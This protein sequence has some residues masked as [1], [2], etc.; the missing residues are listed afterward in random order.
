[1]ILYTF[2]IL[3]SLMFLLV[4]VLLKFEVSVWFNKCINTTFSRR[5]PCVSGVYCRSG[6]SMICLPVSSFSCLSGVWVILMSLSQRLML[7][8]H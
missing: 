4:L 1:M 7:A 6:C 8:I 3:I 5:V 2:E